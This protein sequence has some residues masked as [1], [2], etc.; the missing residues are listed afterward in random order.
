VVYLSAGMSRMRGA[1]GEAFARAPNERAVELL[2]ALVGKAPPHFA[3]T[4]WETLRDV[5]LNVEDDRLRRRAYAAVTAL[6]AKT[7]DRALVKAHYARARAIAE[8][9]GDTAPVAEASS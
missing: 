1:V 9:I 6:A 5:Y 3:R 2:E 4:A 8:A 7:G